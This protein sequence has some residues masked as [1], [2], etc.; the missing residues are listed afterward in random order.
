MEKHIRPEGELKNSLQEPK[1]IL[2]KERSN[3]YLL[4]N[5]LFCW[6]SKQG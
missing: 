4:A 3:T 5:K 1:Q 6:I 2:D